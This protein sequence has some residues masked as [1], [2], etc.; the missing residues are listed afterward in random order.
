MWPFTGNR[1][2]FHDFVNETGKSLFVILPYHH[3]QI[4]RACFLT[5]SR[6]PR[7]KMDRPPAESSRTISS[8]DG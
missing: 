1:T 3:Q 6:F 7:L 4:G 2:C 8:P 5:G